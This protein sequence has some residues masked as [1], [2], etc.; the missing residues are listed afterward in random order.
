M[1]EN[2]FEKVCNTYFVFWL[3]KDDLSHNQEQTFHI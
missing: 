2:V 1:I 3:Q